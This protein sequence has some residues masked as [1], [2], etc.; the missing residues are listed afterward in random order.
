MTKQPS[1]SDVICPFCGGIDFNLL[2]LKMHLENGWCESYNKI[3]VGLELEKESA[4][5]QV[6]KILRKRK[7]MGN[8]IIHKSD[9]SCHNMPAY[10]NKPC[11]CMSEPSLYD[12][13]LERIADEVKQIREYLLSMEFTPEPFYNA[14]VG[15]QKLLKDFPV[16]ILPEIPYRKLLE[17]QELAQKNNGRVAA[18]RNEFEHLPSVPCAFI[19]KTSSYDYVYGK[20][21]KDLLN[22]GA[23]Q[24]IKE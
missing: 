7:K 18:V 24:E 20:V 17:A 3:N 11:D 13:E 12:R 21:I 10:P 1:L 15:L 19:G 22:S 5:R 6:N 16:Q 14:E 9:C 4:V 8:K 23:V 2:G